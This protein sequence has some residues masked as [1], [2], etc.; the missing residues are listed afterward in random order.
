MIAKFLTEL[1]IKSDDYGNLYAET[2]D[3]TF[4]ELV[5]DVF[6]NPYFGKIQLGKEVEPEDARGD[7][8]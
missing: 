1:K 8:L 2:P 4:Y 5:E 7:Y 6:N 3:G